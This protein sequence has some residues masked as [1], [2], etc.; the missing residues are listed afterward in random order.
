[1]WTDI[2]GIIDQRDPGDKFRLIIQLCD[3]FRDLHSKYFK[4]LPFRRFVDDPIGLVDHVC[5][6]NESPPSSKLDRMMGIFGSLYE[7]MEP[8]VN[9]RRCSF[10]KSFFNH[11]GLARCFSFYDIP[12]LKL[13]HSLPGYLDWKSFEN[14]AFPERGNF[15]EL[16]LRFHYEK[17]RKLKHL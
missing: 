3:K 9:K 15:E 16:F 17:K 11:L 2:K 8:S 7:T 13:C 6:Q 10:F 5:F 14:L 4:V 12:Q 1:M